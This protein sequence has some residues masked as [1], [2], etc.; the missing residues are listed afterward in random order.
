MSNDVGNK[1]STTSETIFNEFKKKIKTS[2][3]SIFDL[4]LIMIIILLKLASIK[5]ERHQ[6]TKTEED[7]K[8]IESN[9]ISTEIKENKGEIPSMNLSQSIKV[10]GLA[11][12]EHINNDANAFVVSR[13]FA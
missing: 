6:I 13:T 8:C 3:A 2:Y 11:T 5:H 1:I 7:R 12:K 10:K 9:K 4:F